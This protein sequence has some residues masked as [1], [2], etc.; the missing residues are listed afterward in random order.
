MA[1]SAG[2][3]RCFLVV[4]MLLLCGAMAL[5]TAA[6]GPRTDTPIEFNRDIRPIL[7]DAC[8]HCHGPDKAKRKADLRFDTQEGA[9]AKLGDGFAIVAGKPNESELYRRITAK[10]ERERMPPVK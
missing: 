7:S 5:P 3:R 6:Q 4:T 10:E 8:Y 2:M 1:R 9:F